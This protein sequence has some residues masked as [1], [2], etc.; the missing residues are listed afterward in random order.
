MGASEVVQ[1]YVKQKKSALPRPEK[2]LKGFEKVFLL[3]DQQKTISFSLKED[4]FQY[5]NDLLHKWIMEMGEFE[6]LVGRS[7]RDIRLTDKVNL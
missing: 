4:A 6:I 7:S 1:V 2:E 5:Y 3:A